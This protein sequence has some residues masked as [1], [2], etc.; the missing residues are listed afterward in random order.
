MKSAF[1]ANMSH[2]IRTPLNAII[3]F[4]NLLGHAE[5][6]EDRQEFMKIIETNNDL[7]LHLINDILDLAKIEAGTLEF[8]P[9]EFDLNQLMS[10]IEASSNLR[11]ANPDLS[12]I[13]E[14]RWPECRMT[15]DKNRLSQVVI[16]LINNAIKFTTAG[17][18]RFGYRTENEELLR[19][20]VTDTGCGI[21][22]EKQDAVFHRF[23]KL[24]E[25]VQGTGLG[26]S[27]CQMIVEHFGGDIG[28]ISEE[29]KGST[30]WFTL[31]LQY[32]TASEVHKQETPHPLRV[33][34]VD[35]REKPLI[36]IAEDNANNYKIF[37]AVLQQ[38]YR[39]LHAWNGV[40]AVKMFRV[41]EPHIVLMDLNMPIMD[42]Y[43]AASEIRKIS[44][45]G[46]M[47]V[48]A[49]TAYAFDEHR[50]AYSDFDAYIAKPF[51][52]AVLKQ[53]IAAL[54]AYND[55]PTTPSSSDDGSVEATEKGQKDSDK[56]LKRDDTP[57]KEE[58]EADTSKPS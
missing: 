52:A 8:V 15:I 43:K 58:G 44:P 45:A 24:N 33:A 16:N 19:I 29:G 40:E 31:P 50:L 12:V 2:E 1:L 4:S 11:V 36:L 46:A 25:F 48:I 3:G 49:V 21:P 41:Y 10:E 42:G 54:L 28:V 13:F 55:N 7:L 14:D 9:S 26:L 23:V 18:I 39:L 6:G 53:R 5:S 57:S 37:D 51:R 30:F 17:T 22:K 32:V 47:V 38:D 35:P 20:Y 27:I 34:R 56:D